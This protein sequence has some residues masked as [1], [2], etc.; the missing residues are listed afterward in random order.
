MGLEATSRIPPAIGLGTFRCTG[1][2]CKISV[3]TAIESGIRHIDTASVY[4]NEVEIG[5]AVRS[6]IG[7]GIIERS[8]IFITSKVSPY[9]QGTTKARRAC[10]QILERL[11]IGYVDLMLIHWPG[12]ARQKISSDEN[13]GKRYETWRVMEEFCDKGLIKSL[14]VSNYE[15]QHIQELLSYAKIKPTVNQV[16]CH[17]LYPQTELKRFCLE[18]D[19]K[20]VAYSCFGVGALFNEEEYPEVYQVARETGKSPA[21][22]LL[23]WGLEN[24]CCVLAKSEQPERIREF[25]PEAPGMQPI[26][27]DEATK[28]FHYLS[29]DH[30]RILSRIAERHGVEKFCWDPSGVQ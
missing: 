6:A 2:P 25:S 15:I 8:D 9:E 7:D 13:A 27:L 22:V 17:P 14:G 26:R 11:D 29:D 3:R 28:Q 19:I 21:Q 16:E 4:K 10:E 1:E 30:K 24:D 12:V 18:N 23:A 5:E 20:M